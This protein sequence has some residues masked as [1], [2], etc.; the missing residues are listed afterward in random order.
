MSV[1]LTTGIEDLKKRGSNSSGET[2]LLIGQKPNAA[3]HRFPD[4]G[5]I[6]YN[7]V[8]CLHRLRLRNRGEAHGRSHLV[9]AGLVPAIPI[10]GHCAILIEIAGTSPAMTS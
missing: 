8:V 6:A 5:N 1:P 7:Q 3:R 2:W 4:A 9:M 10:I